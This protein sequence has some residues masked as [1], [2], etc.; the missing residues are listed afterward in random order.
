MAFVRYNAVTRPLHYTNRVRQA[1]LGAHGDVTKFIIP[2]NL[3]AV[4]FYLPKFFEFTIINDSESEP[5]M[6]SRQNTFEIATNNYTTN[7]YYIDDSI[8]R[9]NKGCVFWY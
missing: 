5:N 6:S 9:R 4:I 3:F 8:L 2:V 1:N 7:S